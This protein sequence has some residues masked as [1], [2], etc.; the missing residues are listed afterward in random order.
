VILGLGLLRLRSREAVLEVVPTEGIWRPSYAEG[1]GRV[2]LWAFMVF[3]GLVNL[4]LLVINA[5]PP[6]T[7]SDGSRDAFKGFGFPIIL[8]SLVLFGFSYYVLVFGAA[9]R[10]YPS[11]PPYRE[12]DPDR[13]RVEAQQTTHEAALLPRNSWMN[14]L[15]LAHVRCEIRKDYTYDLRL[16]RVYRFGRRWRIRWILYSPEQV[17]YSQCMKSH[18]RFLTKN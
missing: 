2:A 6:Y 4:S 14:I 8:S 11:G 16:R 17:T 12:D 7:S 3:Y 1:F 13:P 9:P 15:R 18:N 5:I 10:D